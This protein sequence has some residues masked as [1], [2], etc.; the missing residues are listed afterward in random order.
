MLSM[1]LSRQSW[2]HKDQCV[3]VLIP[4]FFGTCSKYFNVA[5]WGGK[6]QQKPTI[7]TL[8]ISSESILSHFSIQSAVIKYSVNTKL[9]HIL[10]K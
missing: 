10:C 6:K 5:W 4:S 2:F 9:G 1:H 7:K 3:C 8:I